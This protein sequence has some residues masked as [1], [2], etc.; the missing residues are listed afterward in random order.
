M[1]EIAATALSRYRHALAV[2]AAA[3]PALLAWPWQQPLGAT[4]VAM[5]FLLPVVVSAVWLGRGPAIAS[6]VTAI[7]LFDVLFVPPQFSLTVSDAR[8][9]VTFAVMLL[10]AVVISYL[11]GRLRQQMQA[12]LLRERQM[13]ALYEFAGRLTGAMQRAAVVD[14][15]RDF[16]HEQLDAKVLLLLLDRDEQLV[17]A[18]DEA[19]LDATDQIAANAAFERG[20]M[21]ETHTLACGERSGIFMPLLG[22]T[23]QRGVFGVIAS[24]CDAQQLAQLKPLVQAVGAIVVT[25]LERLHFVEVASAAELEMS[26]ER[27]RSAILSA[28]SHDIRTPLTALYGLAESLML[29]DPPLPAQLHETLDALR[30]QALQLNSL[31]TNLLEMARLQSATTTLHKEWQPLEEVIGASIKQLQPVLAGHRV[32]VALPQRMPL[33]A[34]DAVLIERV[35]CNLLENAAKH[36]GSGCDILVDAVPDAAFVT[37]RVVNSGSQFPADAAQRLFDALARGDAAGAV[38]GVGIGL[39]ICRAIVEAHGGVIRAA[40]SDDAHACVMFTLPRGVP[41]PMPPESGDG[42]QA[43]Q[44]RGS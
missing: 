22:A 38:P 30:A 20:V 1:R 5:L 34:F 28:L 29:A 39:A 42:A 33:L 36:G 8:Y 2:M 17:T 27:M 32:R 26:A 18:V 24:R 43:P 21:I 31:A 19:G 35:L 14:S 44:G 40:N 11:A 16:V 9:L 10:V 41:P 37:V 6:A 12:A 25:A 23:R 7:L 15:T 13:R 4:N 3:L